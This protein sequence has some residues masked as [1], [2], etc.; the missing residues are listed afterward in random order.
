M[1]G[2]SAA[3][4][5]IAVADLS[6]KVAVLC[7]QYSKKVLHAQADIG[8]LQGQVQR[9]DAVLQNARRLIEGPNSQPLVASREAAKSL[10]EC[11]AELERLRIKLEPDPQ[12]KAMS[13]LGFRALKWPFSS[14]EIEGIM[15]RLEG[16]QHTVTLG[17]QIDQTYAQFPSLLLA[18]AH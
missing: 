4:S 10:E 3:S 1:D 17:L 7:F 14:Q 6:A 13:R 12:R 15:T 2:V 5:V 9:L 18:I 11:K 16:Y 8:R